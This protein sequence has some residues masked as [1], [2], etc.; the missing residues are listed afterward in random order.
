MV[1]VSHTGATKRRWTRRVPVTCRSWPEET[2]RERNRT[3]A[4]GI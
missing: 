4:S 3:Y 1:N 2:Q